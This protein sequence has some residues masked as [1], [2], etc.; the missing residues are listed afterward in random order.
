MA[1]A[2]ASLGDPVDDGPAGI[3]ETGAPRNLVEDLAGRVV[4]GAR[5]RHDAVLLDAH[6]LGV[7]AGDDEPVERMR[8]RV[9]QAS[10]SAE[11]GGEEMAFEVVDRDERDPPRERQRL[12]GRESDEERAD[13][14]RTGRGGDEP[15]VLERDGRRGER[16]LERR[17]EVLE[18]RARGD[19]RHD[20]AVGR[21]R[22]ELG[23]DDVGQ[24]AP[25]AVEHGD[26]GLVAGGFDAEDQHDDCRLSIVDCRFLKALFGIVDR[27]S[28]IGNSPFIALLR[29]S[30]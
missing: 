2:A 16:L 24:D 30:P 22:G 19:L 6:E 21:V 1:I 11:E 18:V 17:R 15:D 14:T 25:V 12:R 26:R 27:Q 5:E 13:Q 28:P 9:G 10:A 23:G 3:A 7:A 20:A 29:L 8:H 4:A